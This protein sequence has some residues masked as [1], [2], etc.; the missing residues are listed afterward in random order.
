VASAT[1]RN[2]CGAAASFSA[3]PACT[4]LPPG[5]GKS[6]ADASAARSNNDH[7]LGVDVTAPRNLVKEVGKNPFA[8]VA[9]GLAVLLLGAA[10][11]PQAVTPGGRTTDLIARERSVL[12]LGGGVALTVGLIVLVLT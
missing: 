9:L 4:L 1:Q 3:F 6:A 5:E 8:L 2:V 7:V 10:A 12:V 11:I